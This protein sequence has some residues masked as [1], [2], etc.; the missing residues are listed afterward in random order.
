MAKCVILVRKLRN[1]HNNTE[2]N[3]LQLER[4]QKLLNPAVAGV[5]RHPPF[6]G[7]GGR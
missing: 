4:F 5:F 7:G 6:A 3:Q 2:Y 1:D